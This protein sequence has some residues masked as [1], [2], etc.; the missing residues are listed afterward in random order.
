VRKDFFAIFLFSHFFVAVLMGGSHMFFAFF[1]DQMLY[2]TCFITGMAYGCA[3]AVSTT[4]ISSLYGKK[5]C[6][7]NIGVISIAPAVSGIIFGQINGKLYDLQGINCMGTLCFRNSF[8]VTGCAALAAVAP[9]VWLVIR[10]PPYG[11]PSLLVD[12]ASASVNQ[13]EVQPLLDAQN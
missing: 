8:I 9:A 12:E 13:K 1:Q 10:T 6:G 5:Y 2:P 7:T 11:R 3:F 4:I